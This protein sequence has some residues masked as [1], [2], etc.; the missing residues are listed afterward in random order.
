MKE[1]FEHGLNF[2]D[3]DNICV[4]VMLY[5]YKNHIPFTIGTV[6]MKEFFEHGLNFPD[7]DNICVKV[8]V[9]RFDE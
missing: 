7:D 9:K 4:K 5:S 1:F 6:S 2:P 3:D 8:M